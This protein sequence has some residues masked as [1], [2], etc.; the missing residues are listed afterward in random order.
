MCLPASQRPQRHGGGRPR[1]RQ[2]RPQGAAHGTTS[3][4]LNLPGPQR[5]A[6]RRPAGCRPQARRG[7][8]SDAQPRKR[9]AA[10]VGGSPGQAEQA[11]PPAPPAVGHE[12]NW[13][14]AAVPDP[15][16]SERPVDRS[17]GRS[18]SIRP[19]AG[20]SSGAA[21]IGPPAVAQPSRCRRLGVRLQRQF[22]RNARASPVPPAGGA[23]KRQC[24]QVRSGPAAGRHQ[25]AGRQE[26]GAQLERRSRPRTAER[27]VSR[28]RTSG[29]RPQHD[30]HAL[31]LVSRARNPAPW[32]GG[33]RGA[34]EPGQ[35]NEGR[36]GGETRA[37]L[38]AQRKTSAKLTVQP[39]PEVQQQQPGL[40]VDATADRQRAQDNGYGRAQAGAGAAPHRPGAGPGQDAAP[41][42]NP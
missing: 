11:A 25:R 10:T 35:P 40:T 32:P 36:S 9:A 16:G 24:E 3:R 4:L 41:A 39:E 20:P 38:V 2:G 37:R 12:T 17:P 18:G 14:S 29:C 7:V 22:G 6:G 33:G 8:R 34:V 21:R 30:D 1:K 31:H 19:T 28:P 42:Q 15:S 5:A 26:H 27:S 13:Y 23:S